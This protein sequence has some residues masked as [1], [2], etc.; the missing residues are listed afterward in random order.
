MNRKIKKIRGYLY[1]KVMKSRYERHFTDDV[2]LKYLKM[3][4]AQGKTLIVVLSSFTRQGVAARY[5]YVKTLNDINAPKL[6][7]LDDFGLD[8]RGSY[9]L[10]RDGGDEIYRSTRRLIDKTKVDVRAERIIYCGS[11]KGGWAALRLGV[12]DPNGTVIAGAPQYLLGD[13]AVSE[14]EKENGNKQLLPYLSSGLKEETRLKW[15]NGILR[16][17]IARNE[18]SNPVYL[19]YST[20]EHTYG[21]HIRFLLEDLSAVGRE[22]SVS[23]DDYTNHNDIALHFPD[24]LHS[25]ISQLVAEQ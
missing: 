17:E 11:S 5:N 2:D 4:P 7:I 18:S 6:F 3:G 16:N 10:G 25:T 8:G 13:Y 24:Y 9:Y 15:L 1:S 12:A 14:Y 23:E 19:C 21:E 22:V 20:E